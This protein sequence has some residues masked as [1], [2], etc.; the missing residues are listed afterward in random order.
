MSGLEAVVAVSLA[1]NVLQFVDFTTRLCIRIREYSSTLSLPRRLS[2]HAD[3][4]LD[5]LQVLDGLAKTQNLPLGGQILT[6]CQKHAED[7]SGLLESLKDDGK[8]R[9]SR[10]KKAWKSLGKD[11]RLQEIQTILDSLVNILALQLHV[12]TK[13]ITNAIEVNTHSILERQE[14]QAAF[15]ED[16]HSVA[17]LK[18][19]ID[20]YTSSAQPI[21]LVPTGRNPDF[22]GRE[23]FLKTLNDR[24]STKTNS[25]PIAVLCGLGGVGK[26][27]IALEYLWQC[28][29]QSPDLGAFWVHAANPARFLESYKR[30]AAEYNIPGRDDP[31]SDVLQIVRN[32][33]E[34]HP[35]GPW[36][37]VVDNV[38][39]HSMF[40]GN[41]NSVGNTLRDYIPQSSRGS[42]VFTTRNRDVG[43]DLLP[44]RDPIMIASMEIEEARAMLGERIRSKST[45]GEQLQL[46][47][48][49]TSLPL[50]ISQAAAFMV[51]RHKSISDY[52]KLYDES[53]GMRIKLLGQ[54]FN[55]H[56]R[57]ARQLES[58]VVTW[59]ISFNLIKSENPRS[60]QM[61]SLMCH[62]DRQ[63]IPYSLLIL[64]D[65]DNFDFEEAIGVL[66]SFSLITLSPQ[67]S[68][69]S[70]HSL[71]C[72]AVLA[73]LSEFENKRDETA[74]Q[75]LK[76]V[77]N[78]FPKGFFETWDT[79]SMLLPHAEAVLRYRLNTADQSTLFARADL[80][81]NV[82]AYLRK[83]GVFE[84]SEIRAKESMDIFTQAFGSEDPKTLSSTA[85]YA[86]IVGK[87]GR[88]EEAHELERKVLSVR[89]KTLGYRHRDTLESLNA[90]GSSLQ[91]QGR[92]K[93]AAQLHR[94]ELD[95]K[96]K[97]LNDNP[98]DPMLVLDVLIATNNI[99]RGLASSGNL[100][101]AEQMYRESLARSI[102]AIGLLHPETFIT[103][104]QLA[105]VVRDRGNF[106]EAEQLYTTLL[107][108]RVL[109]LG[110]SHPDTL[111]TLSNLAILAGKQGNYQQAE[112]TYRRVLEVEATVLGQNHPST[113]NSI[114]N[115]AC[116]LFQQAKVAEAEAMFKQCLRAQS[117][118]LWLHHPDLLLTRRNTAAVL[119]KQAKF[120]EA[121][122]LDTETLILADELGEDADAERL[123]TL[124]NLA[125]G[126]DEEGD[127]ARAES[128]RRKELEIRRRIYGDEHPDTYSCLDKIA[129]VVNRQGKWKEAVGLW[130][131]VINHASE[132]LGFDHEDVLRL[133]WNFSVV[134]R[135]NEDFVKAG[136]GFQEIFEA[137]S[138]KQ[139]PYN[140]SALESLIQLAWAQHRQE[141]HREAEA[142]YR[143]YIAMIASASGPENS[144]I[145]MA[146]HNLAC[147]LKYQDNSSEE[148][149]IWFRRAYAGRAKTLGSDH[150]N[151]VNSLDHLLAHLA[152]MGRADQAKALREQ[153]DPQDCWPG[154]DERGSK[155]GAGAKIEEG[156]D[157]E[158]KN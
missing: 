101:E 51:K 108:D 137:R 135:D 69:C 54:R 126:L 52:I 35:H 92:H 87:R 142:S 47:E 150:V 68:S 25:V 133:L 91:W 53:E 102:T 74:V 32:W 1:S 89:V 96:Q 45:T 145:S 138:R 94:R 13:S 14:E 106:E 33:L 116:S 97:I 67:D 149:E 29:E 153:L 111:I 104:G 103:R 81:L 105:A 122:Q 11:E 56:G 20:E 30:I 39:D 62:L 66:E 158:R 65:E 95:E 100:A 41:P 42:L 3:R 140:P 19:Q 70:T 85:N 59:W 17:K 18:L 5:L 4:L 31:N 80:L 75:A 2:A 50:A 55:H 143:R 131:Q 93:E 63:K 130:R 10:V 9:F 152:D 123:Q 127:L 151:T 99:A 36:L 7:L 26:S 83:I 148:A 125:N 8:S 49:L 147:I 134:C 16:L 86:M 109:I 34:V 37:M 61:L 71:V 79:C 73:W 43:L 24:L 23:G 144:L 84:K 129:D 141:K 98:S 113:L 118:A 77:S 48:R 46:I 146:A 58:V 112:E 120:T 57:E 82:S 154:S 28:K 115:I 38:D 132:T 117:S 27:Q 90:L 40:F 107:E 21:W 114:H 110:E 76:A 124:A 119:R 88:W 128:I 44:R 156:S 22:V 155:E 121:N 60:A 15:L 78:L 6:Q 12:E 136:G 64:E 157:E 72:I 139:G